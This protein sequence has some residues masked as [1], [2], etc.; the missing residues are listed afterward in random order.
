MIVQMPIAKSCVEVSKCNN[1][2]C[3]IGGDMCERL[4]DMVYTLFLMRSAFMT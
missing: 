2:T 1:N 4:K 3:A